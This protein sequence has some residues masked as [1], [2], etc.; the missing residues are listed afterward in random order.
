MITLENT[1]SRSINEQLHAAHKEGHG[2]SGQ[3]L[4]LVVSTDTRDH[5]RVLAEATEAGLDHPARILVAVRGCTDT[6]SLHA[7]IDYP[8]AT[9]EVITLRFSCEMD[10]HADEVLFPLLLPELPVVVWYPCFHLDHLERLSGLSKRMIFD[11]TRSDDP[12]AMLSWL[13]ERHDPNTTDLAWT[14]L[15]T[16]RARLVA[17]LD[18]VRSTILGGQVYAEATNTPALLMRSWLELRLGVPID[19]IATQRQD[20]RN[21]DILGL[22]S[23][24]LDSKLGPVSIGREND[25]DGNLCL[26]GQPPRHIALT[27][28][29]IQAMLAEELTQ[30]NGDA[31]FDAVMNHLAGRS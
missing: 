13:V 2:A 27:K 30:L 8:S 22:H 17:A 19:F 12:L 9:T 20:Q 28:R 23:V 31:T 29:T 3:V 6:E 26:P 18:Q 11:S 5:E 25:T 15:T 16:W 21:P 10:H 1:D 7:Q 4:T 14:R 24:T